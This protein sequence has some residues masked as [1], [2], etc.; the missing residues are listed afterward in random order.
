MIIFSYFEGT[1]KGKFSSVHVSKAYRESRN[2]D[3]LFN[4]RADGGKS[5]PSHPGRFTQGNK[6][7]IKL[8]GLSAYPRAYLEFSEKQK[9]SCLCRD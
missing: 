8:I 3:P 2:I 5:S 9:I 1:R 7:T 4:F 6:S